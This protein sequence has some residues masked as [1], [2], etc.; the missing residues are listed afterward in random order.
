MGSKGFRGKKISSR[1]KAKKKWERYYKY[2]YP[3]RKNDDVLIE[4]KNCKVK[5]IV[6]Y[7]RR[8]QKFCSL[9]CAATYNNL[10]REKQRRK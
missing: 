3:Y 6:D 2:T 7:K 9:S 8:F 5:I 1:L 4:C 10:K